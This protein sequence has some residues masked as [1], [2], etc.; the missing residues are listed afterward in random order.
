VPAK[1]EPIIS[2]QNQKEKTEKVI[3]VAKYQLQISN[4]EFEFK[5]NEQK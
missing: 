2:I 5:Q 1:K 4:K 3:K